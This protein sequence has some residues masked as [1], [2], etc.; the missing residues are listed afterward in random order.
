MRVSFRTVKDVGVLPV[1]LFIKSLPYFPEIVQR[2][3]TGILVKLV[4]SYYYFPASHV[5]RTVNDLCAIIGR[6]DPLWITQTLFENVGIVAR[7]LG[8]LL[9]EGSESVSRHIE[10][11]E[12]T[13]QRIE[14][15]REKYGGG[16]FVV[17]HCTGS[18]LSVALVGR[19]LPVVVMVRE[20]KSERRRRLTREYFDK[21]APETIEVRRT[22]PATIARRILRAL[23]EKKLIIGTTDLIRR[24]EDTVEVKIFGRPAWLPGWPA[25]FAARRNVPIVPGYVYMR[26]GR[27]VL[28]C[29]E[30]YFEKDL[31]LS[32]QR[33]ADYF[34]RA[35]R[36][37][38]EDWPFMFEKRWARLIAAAAAGNTGK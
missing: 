35:I 21:L 25:R 34:E 22:P 31:A 5:R 13:L 32:T 29:D 17:P 2:T 8:K 33:W 10:F 15:I 24:K 6:S 9:H 38:P 26:D 20:S 12:G 3:A 28:T 36:R 37:W 18:V 14:G 16:I 27:L 4:G 23:K 19:I 30:P 7:L 1:H 11:E